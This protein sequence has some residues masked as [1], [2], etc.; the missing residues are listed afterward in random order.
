MKSLYCPKR[1]QDRK[2][3][4]R[5]KTLS[6]RISKSNLERKITNQRDRYRLMQKELDIKPI[7]LTQRLVST[8]KAHSINDFIGKTDVKPKNNVLL[9]PGFGELK[10]KNKYEFAKPAFKIEPIFQPQ[11]SAKPLT[12]MSTQVMHMSNPKLKIS[13]F[14]GDPLE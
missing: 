11:F 12:Q 4:S 2:K 5:D 9:P 13:E 8:N 10:P 3:S 1:S 7:S 14:H 6:L